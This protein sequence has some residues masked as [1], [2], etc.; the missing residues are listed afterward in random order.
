MSKK[1][2]SLFAAGVA[3]WTVASTI[4]AGA[5]A[6]APAAPIRHT[7]Y[8]FTY[9]TQSDLTEQTSGLEG[10][11]ESGMKHYGA[12]TQDQGTV[13]VDVNGV[14]ADGGLL[15]SVSESARQDRSAAPVTCAV[16]G[17]TRVVCEPDKK[18]NEEEYSLLRFMG[19]QFFDPSKLDPRQHWHIASDSNGFSMASDFTVSGGT[20]SAESITE[21]TT[22]KAG[23]SQPFTTTTDG[24]IMYNADLTIP[25]SISQ[26]SFQRQ[27]QGMGMDNLQHT[28]IELHLQSDSMA[29][30]S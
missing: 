24:K 18:V 6:N 5:V 23:G 13:T 12:G 8:S 27:S 20:T 26:D 22:V 19:R 9:L 25:I 7:V 11:P 10:G 17:D 3:A 28:Q 1:S 16:Y 21:Q 30:K 4:A 2:L 14:Q 29:N 15:V